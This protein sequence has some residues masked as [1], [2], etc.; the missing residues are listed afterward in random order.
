MSASVMNTFY[1]LRLRVACWNVLA[2]CYSVGQTGKS[3]QDLEF[4]FRKDKIK[5]ILSNSNAN[6]LCLQEIDHYDDFYRPFMDEIGMQSIYH[7]RPFREDGC[8]IAYQSSSFEC[9]EVDNIDF[10]QLASSIA[11]RLHFSS[12]SSYFDRFVKHNVALSLRLRDKTEPSREFIVS[13]G[14]LYW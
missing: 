8:L 11:A 5:E 4:S 14:H 12:T 9:M 2:D 13:C 7:K 1:P 10:D 6:I 3:S